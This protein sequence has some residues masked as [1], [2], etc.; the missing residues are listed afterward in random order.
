MSGV[1][2]DFIAP[3]TSPQSVSPKALILAGWLA[4]RLGWRATGDHDER[5]ENG[6]RRFFVEKN[7]RTIAV[8]F[9]PTEHDAVEPGG[10]ASV[11]LIVDSET[12]KS[13]VAMRVEDGRDLETREASDT[14]TRTTRVVSSADKSEAELL[15]AEL[16][17]LSHDRI[18]EEAVLKAIEL[19]DAV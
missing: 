2:I 10:I 15:A 19:F 11:E 17:I 9:N 3:S 7:G 5:A 1:R 6:L 12:H 8:E 16:E 18:Y 14:K 13:F 4:S